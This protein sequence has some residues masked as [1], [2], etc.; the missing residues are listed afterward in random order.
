MHRIIHRLSS[1]NN[2]FPARAFPVSCES[3]SQESSVT[4]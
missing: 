2:P 1:L 4:I 3:T